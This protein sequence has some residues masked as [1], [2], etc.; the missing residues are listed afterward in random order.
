MRTAYLIDEYQRTYF[1]IDSFE[2]LFRAAYD[3]DFAPIY[4]RYSETAPIAAGVVLPTDQLRSA[5][6]STA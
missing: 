5:A 3:T 1:V 2:Q 6:Q 4:R